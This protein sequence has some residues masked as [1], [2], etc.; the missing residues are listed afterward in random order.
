MADS[1]AITSDLT[2]VAGRLL[3]LTVANTA[4]ADSAPTGSVPTC[5]YILQTTILLKG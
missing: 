5:C 1:S 4:A 2:K 3:T